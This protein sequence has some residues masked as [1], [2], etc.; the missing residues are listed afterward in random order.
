[1]LYED[2]TERLESKL[3]KIVYFSLY[4]Y[5]Y[6]TRVLSNELICPPPEDLNRRDRFL[7]GV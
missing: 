7:P 5:V 4:N 2:F 6:V 3:C 1:M